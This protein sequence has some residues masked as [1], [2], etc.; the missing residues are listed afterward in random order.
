ML[1]SS[2]TCL[3]VPYLQEHYRAYAGPRG[4][5]CSAKGV[6]SLLWHLMRGPLPP[7]PYS[8]GIAENLNVFFYAAK[9]HSY[10]QQNDGMS[11]K[12]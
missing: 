6:R 7:A 9:P 5:P 10:W 2:L 11:D 8:R 3:Q 1:M 12:L 4:F